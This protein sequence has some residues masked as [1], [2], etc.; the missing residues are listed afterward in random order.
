[1]AYNVENVVMES[2]H[3]SAR[4]NNDRFKMCADGT[5]I[6]FVC[7]SWVNISVGVV[8]TEPTVGDVLKG[9]ESDIILFW[10]WTSKEFYV[11]STSIIGERVKDSGEL[12]AILICAKNNLIS[13]DID[14]RNV[15]NEN[16]EKYIGKGCWTDP[17]GVKFRPYWWDHPIEFIPCSDNTCND[18]DFYK[19]VL[20]KEGTYVGDTPCQWCQNSPYKVTSQMQE[21]IKCNIATAT[22]KLNK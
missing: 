15:F 3:I 1:M 5:A 11:E 12:R 21:T 22:N 14:W 6:I 13:R 17:N 9:Q 19:R 16:K 10:N 4:K 8:K 2:V 7:G 20:T 18:C